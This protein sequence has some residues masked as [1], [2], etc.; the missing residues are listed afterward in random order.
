[1]RSIRPLGRAAA[2]TRAEAPSP[3]GGSPTPGEVLGEMGL[4]L[5]AHL[6]AALAVTLIL[7]WGGIV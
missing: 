3:A 6:L 7:R 2:D 1:M 4:L 5:A